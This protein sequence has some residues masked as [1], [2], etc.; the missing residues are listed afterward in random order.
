MV[1]NATDANDE[2]LIAA[3]DEAD[4]IYL[5]GGNPAHL[6]DTLAGSRL[7]AALRAA[8]HRG[9]IV[10]GSSAGAMALGDRMRFRGE[11]SEA[12]GL[13]RGV[14]VLPHHERSD[15]ERVAAEPGGG[16]AGGHNGAGHRRGD[17]LRQRGRRLARIRG[18]GGCA[19][20]RGRVGSVRG[21]GS[22]WAGVVKARG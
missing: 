21:G 22:F 4:V 9:A 12:L 11:W 5:T 19:V 16:V 1:L 2:A 18:G 8:L 13:A 20:S 15:P 7:A 10:A 3:A 6:L 17:G 14:A